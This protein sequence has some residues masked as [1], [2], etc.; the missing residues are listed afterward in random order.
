MYLHECHLLHKL[1]AMWEDLLGETGRRLADRF[2]EHP[3]DV[4]ENDTDASKPVAC[5]FNF[6]IHSHHNMTLCGLSLH[7]ENTESRKSLEQK[8]IFQLV[9]LYPHG[10]NERLSFH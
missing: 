3:R 2:R 9:T 7:H 1:H 4:E 10:I 8:F 5:R 6:H